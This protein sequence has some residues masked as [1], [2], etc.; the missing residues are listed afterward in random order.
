[1]EAARQVVPKLINDQF[2]DEVQ[3]QEKDRIASS[4]DGGIAK[5]K[6]LEERRRRN[7]KTET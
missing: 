5:C 1:V 3:E 7:K 6:N 4:Y 2:M